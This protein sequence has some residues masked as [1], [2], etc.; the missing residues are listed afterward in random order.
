V[1]FYL[2]RHGFAGRR[3]KRQAGIIFRA[4]YRAEQRGFRCAKILLLLT[5]LLTMFGG[6]IYVIHLQVT[7]QFFC[8][9]VQVQF[10]DDF[11]ARLGTFSGLYDLSSGNSLF[12][13]R[14]VA[15]VERRSTEIGISQ[16]RFAYCNDIGAWTLRLDNR[17]QA[18]SDPCDWLAR[19]S[20]TET[21]DLVDTSTLLWYVQDQDSREVVLDPFYLACFDCSD[22]AEDCGGHGFCDNAVCQCDN[23]DRFGLSCEFAQPCSMLSVD[24]SGDEFVSTRDWAT[25]YATFDV[26]GDMVVAYDRPV[27]IHDNGE[28]DYDVLAYTGRRW[29]LTSSQTFPLEGENTT[30]VDLVSAA[31]YSFIELVCH[32]RVLNLLQTGRTHIAA[33]FCLTG[34]L[35]SNLFSRT[36]PKFD[37]LLSQRASRFSDSERCKVSHVSVIGRV[38]L[39]LN[40]CYL[41]GSALNRS[42]LTRNLTPFLPLL[43]DPEVPQLA[44]VGTGPWQINKIRKSEALYLIRQWILCCFAESVT[45]SAILVSMMVFVLTVHANALLVRPETCARSHQ[46]VMGIAIFSS[47]LQNS[48]TM[49][50]TVARLLASGAFLRWLGD[51]A[52]KR[53][54]RWIQYMMSDSKPFYVDLAAPRISN[55]DTM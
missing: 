37:F 16:A 5:I 23:D 46:P 24:R 45:P 14:R 22:S 32:I 50:A 27:Y 49:V 38:P 28:G 4:K 44:Y 31:K 11:V 7:G 19:S 42:H 48:T 51:A 35:L 36:G 15:Y 6:W 26:A 3:C 55:A 47:T 34:K 25:S 39:V 9:T 43:L 12:S 29:G 41:Y 54:Q 1:F 52:L 21:F 17:S 33:L 18:E 40:L 10:G 8:N 13:Q 20:E 30:K 53:Q 2:S